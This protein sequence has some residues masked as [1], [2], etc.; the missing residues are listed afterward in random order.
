MTC[1]RRMNRG[2]FSLL[3]VLIA[4]GI[5]GIGIIAVMQLFPPALRQARGATDQR[6]AATLA[7]SELNRMLAITQEE[8]FIEWT[9]L[10]EVENTLAKLPESDDNY[11]LRTQVQRLPGTSSVYRVTMSIELSDGQRQTYVTY[12]TRR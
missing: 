12:V 11:T 10:K 9:R 8:N 6:A 7:E 1:K 5:M 3:E 2:G 4:M